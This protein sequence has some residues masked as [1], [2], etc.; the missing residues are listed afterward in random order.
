[1]ADEGGG[2]VPPPGGGPDQLQQQP[3]IPPPEEDSESGGGGSQSDNAG[4]NDIPD[5][6]ENNEPPANAENVIPPANAENVIPPA[7]A[8]NDVID[9]AIAEA[10]RADAQRAQDDQIIADLH[11]DYLD[12][13]RDQYMQQPGNGGF[14]GLRNPVMQGQRLPGY[15]AGY[16]PQQ[17]NAQY[18]LGFPEQWNP[19]AQAR[20]PQVH[21]AVAVNDRAVREMLE[22]RDGERAI[23]YF[24]NMIYPEPLGE[25]IDNRFQNYQHEEIPRMVNGVAEV[26]AQGLPV[27]EPPPWNQE[28]SRIEMLHAVRDPLLE[29]ERRYQEGRAELRE[30][31]TQ[32]SEDHELLTHNFLVGTQR[33]TALE[34]DVA[35]EGQNQRVLNQQ[36]QGQLTTSRENQNMILGMLR[37]GQPRR[38]SVQTNNGPQE[39]GNVTFRATSQTN[40]LR[41]RP[42]TSNFNETRRLGTSKLDLTMPKHQDQVQD[43]SLFES[44]GISTTGRSREANGG[45]AGLL[46]NMPKVAANRIQNILNLTPYFEDIGVDTDNLL[47]TELE[48]QVGKHNVIMA[49]NQRK[50]KRDNEYLS[51]IRLDCPQIEDALEDVVVGVDDPVDKIKRVKECLY[52]MRSRY[53]QNDGRQADIS[54]ALQRLDKDNGIIKEAHR[55]KEAAQVLKL[56]HRAL[57]NNP[58][59]VPAPITGNGTENCNFSKNIFLSMENKRIGTGYETN[60]H[61]NPQ[62]A[63]NILSQHISENDLSEKCALHFMKSHMTTKMQKII[64]AR[65]KSERTFDEIWYDVQAATKPRINRGDLNKCIH[66]LL[67]VPPVDLNEVVNEIQGY[68]TQLHENDPIET[69]QDVMDMEYHRDMQTLVRKYYRPYESV[70]DQEVSQR[71][72][73]IRNNGG[74]PNI[75]QIHLDIFQETVRNAIPDGKL[76]QMELDLR[77]ETQ[78]KEAKS[79]AR[80]TLT[81]NRIEEN[82]DYDWRQTLD[83]KIE[84]VSK[85]ST[86]LVEMFNTNQLDRRDRQ[87]P[88]TNQQGYREQNRGPSP[89]NMDTNRPQGGGV[90]LTKEQEKS[91]QRCLLCGMGNHEHAKCKRYEGM[92]PTNL[93]CET[94]PGFHPQTVICWMVQPAKNPNYSQPQQPKL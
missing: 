57:R 1:M 78:P 55:K 87:M 46:E 16:M 48:K 43:K 76:E 21:A 90:N 81:L 64:Q 83:E 53:A 6:A 58:T 74:K 65:E 33:A 41:P 18:R 39:G 51:K 44:I 40:L 14:R 11:D 15:G 79:G 73:Q 13:A 31:Y 19:L 80:G 3:I 28:L 94:C 71:L 91:K 62:Y 22:R 35:H 56:D 9:P 69:R 32:M 45:M 36:F 49:Q 63:M 2:G 24:P 27:M 29:V 20:P 88:P 82:T 10:A 30:R 89:P 67:K 92:V 37:N 66:D 47:K 61:T 17:G 84:K 52:Y 8:E 25:I 50:G 4:G 70:I 86:Q 60:T 93:R 23:G 54:F 38:N 72:A 59:F 68:R 42:A 85:L 34:G 75:T 5:N 77:D 12:R 7:N 26:N